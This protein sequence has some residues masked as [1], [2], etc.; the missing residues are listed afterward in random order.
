MLLAVLLIVVGMVA[1]LG[2]VTTEEAEVGGS[3]V[4]YSV[5]ILWFL[6]FTAVVRA[7]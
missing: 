5:R 7:A 3:I 1:R 2:W 6:G 4:K